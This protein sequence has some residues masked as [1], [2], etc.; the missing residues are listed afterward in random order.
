MANKKQ[1]STAGVAVSKAATAINAATAGPSQPAS[2]TPTG[3]VP[4]TQWAAPMPS[5][6][7]PGAAS[8]RNAAAESAAAAAAAAASTHTMHAPHARVAEASGPGSAAAPSHS[9][10]THN[11]N[12]HAQAA[13]GAAPRDQRNAALDRSGNSASAATA[14]AAAAPVRPPVATGDSKLAEHVA[15]GERPHASHAYAHTD[16]A[17]ATGSQKDSFGAASTGVNAVNPDPAAAARAAY[18]E[19][20]VGTGIEQLHAFAKTGK[21][22]KRRKLTCFEAEELLVEDA[23]AMLQKANANPGQCH[24]DVLKE[25]QSVMKRVRCTIVWESFRFLYVSVYTESVTSPRISVRA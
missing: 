13:S 23:H 14:T 16:A 25:L 5:N 20:G 12:T 6:V 18:G 3:A 17:H 4:T 8:G 24:P 11:E 10:R 15:T 2:V 7:V 19:Q 21:A 1:R 22:K 9:A